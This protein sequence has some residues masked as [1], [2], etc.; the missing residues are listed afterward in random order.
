LDWL[1]FQA[2]LAKP[3]RLLLDQVHTGFQN[4]ALHDNGSGVAPHP[5]L[6]A[7]VKEAAAIQVQTN[8]ILTIPTQLMSAD[9]D[10]ISEIHEIV[11]TGRVH[12]TSVNMQ[13]N[14]GALRKTFSNLDR[15]GPLQIDF[16]EQRAEKLWNSVI[17]LGPL[18]LRA[19]E[20][21]IDTATR[22]KLRDDLAKGSDHDSVA[23]TFVPASDKPIE[24]IYPNWPKSDSN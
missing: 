24:I 14:K 18:K 1:Q 23:I 4:T 2:A 22:A 12:A 9:S 11:T 17:N 19:E 20:A 3:G 6:V 10:L 7:L 15:P 5:G 21:I 13:L 8:T 16:K